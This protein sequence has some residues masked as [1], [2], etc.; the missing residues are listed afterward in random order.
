M[1]LNLGGRL[2]PRLPTITGNS[3]ILLIQE[4]SA[5]R[6]VLEARIAPRPSMHVNLSHGDPLRH[7]PLPP[8]P[9]NINQ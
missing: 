9:H 5:K 2:H 8:Y 1:K 4:T 7:L 3:S 6:N